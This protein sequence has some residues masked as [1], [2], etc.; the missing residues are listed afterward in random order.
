MV[1]SP[2]VGHPVCKQNML[3]L[4]NENF[5]CEKHVSL[6]TAFILQTVHIYCYKFIIFMGTCLHK[7]I[8]FISDSDAQ[9]Y[10]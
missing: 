6:F 8:I 1:L 3:F 9:T 10:F 2:H 7:T 4:F 5:V